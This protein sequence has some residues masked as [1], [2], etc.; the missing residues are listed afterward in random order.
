MGRSAATLSNPPVTASTS[1]DLDVRL[2]ATLEAADELLARMARG[3]VGCSQA[4]VAL[5]GFSEQLASDR[6]ARE[7]LLADEFGLAMARA[8]GERQALARQ[9]AARQQHKSS[10]PR[11][12][13]PPIMKLIDGGLAAAGDGAALPAPLPTGGNCHARGL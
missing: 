4:A 10:G 8:D 6:V 7:D 9:A 5:A 3:E 12:R 2:A 11:D 13:Q 1:A